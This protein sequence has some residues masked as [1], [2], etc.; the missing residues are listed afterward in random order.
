MGKSLRR[1]I[2]LRRV[3]VNRNRSRLIEDHDP[4]AAV[5]FARKG[6]AMQESELLRFENASEFFSGMTE[7]E[8]AIVEQ[9]PEVKRR[10]RPPK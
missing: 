6:Q 1:V 3:W 5:F 4:E 10:G 7:A 2:A 8:P 9:A